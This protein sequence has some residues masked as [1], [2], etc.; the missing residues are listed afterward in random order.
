MPVRELAHTL[1]TWSFLNTTIN[2]RFT[3]YTEASGVSYIP[4]LSR[5]SRRWQFHVSITTAQRLAMSTSETYLTAWPD[6]GTALE[7]DIDEFLGRGLDDVQWK[8]VLE[9][10]GWIWNTNLR[11][12]IINK[13]FVYFRPEIERLL[14]EPKIAQGTSSSKSNSRVSIHK[15]L[16][17]EIW[18]DGVP[19]EK[20][21]RRRTKRLYGKLAK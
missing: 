6:S 10:R 13:E 16:M 12:T 5:R 14:S 1:R 3:L 15:R 21:E 18:V 8:R 17:G 4:F 20:G 19:D 7:N 2:E 9:A 11:N